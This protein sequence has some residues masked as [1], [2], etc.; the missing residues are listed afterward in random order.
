MAIGPK[1]RG[2]LGPFERP[3]SDIYRNM[4]MNLRSLRRKVEE[5]LP[6]EGSNFILEVGCGEGV[7][8]EILAEIFPQAYIAGIDVT[9]RIGRMYRGNSSKVCF[10]RQTVQDFANLNSEK[11]DIVVIVDVLHHIPPI[12]HHEFLSDVYKL[13]KVGGLFFFKD[14]I[15]S[16]TPIHLFSYLMESYITGDKVS[17]LSID[18]LTYL[19][20]KVFGENSILKRTAIPPW[21]NNVAFLVKEE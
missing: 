20:R 18:E 6:H 1:I 19:I 10:I 9:P 7:I 21:K 12:L 14:W 15:H 17:Y 13:I 5:W 2:L 4:F 11:F 8:I 3:V 16:K